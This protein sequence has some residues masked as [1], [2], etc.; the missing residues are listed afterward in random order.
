MPI[1][2]ACRRA[3][4]GRSA[5]ASGDAGI[6]RRLRRRA[7]LGRRQRL[8]GSAAADR[9]ERVATPGRRLAVQP[10]RGG[11]PDQRRRRRRGRTAAPARGHAASRST[12]NERVLEMLDG[13]PDLRRAR[14]RRS[15]RAGA[16][17]VSEWQRGPKR[18]TARTLGIEVAPFPVPGKIPLYLEGEHGRKLTC[19]R[20]DGEHARPRI[21]AQ[22]TRASSMSRTAPR[23]PTDA[24]RA[25]CRRAA[26]LLRRHA[27]HRRRDDRARASAGRP[28]GAWA[29]SASI[30]PDGSLAKLKP[31]GIGR[32]IFIHINNTN[33]DPAEG[34]RRARRAR[35][36]QASRWPSTAWRSACELSRHRRS[37][38][39]P[40]RSRRRCAGSA[41]SATTTATRSTGCCTAGG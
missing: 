8:A 34:Q 30:G 11:G 2:S 25:D 40:T 5:G 20:A 7:A 39:A 17:Q 3:R 16:L 19:S 10:D 21:R 33:P 13:E 23:S 4:R 27:V 24:G 36:G 22:A 26:R 9:G 35:G 31:L 14:P 12:R 29:T 37:G 15:C 18:R 41:T 6:D 28:A 32:T 38:R 1:R